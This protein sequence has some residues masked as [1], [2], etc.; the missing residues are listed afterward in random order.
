MCR[1]K[2]IDKSKYRYSTTTTQT[3]TSTSCFDTN[4]NCALIVANIGYSICPCIP[5]CKKTCNYCSTPVTSTTVVPVNLKT[6]TTSNP[7]C[8]DTNTNCASIV[9]NGGYS[10]CPYMPYC[11]KT[12]N[13]C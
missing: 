10:D 13:Y 11:K 8:F 1:Y 4:S 2:I 6:T 3:T 5:Y 12:C 7:N 9:A